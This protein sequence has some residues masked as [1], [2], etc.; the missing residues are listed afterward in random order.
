MSSHN[1]GVTLRHGAGCTDHSAC[2]WHVASRRRSV[3]V[4]PDLGS[5]QIMPNLRCLQ[6]KQSNTMP[7][8]EGTCFVP[9]SEFDRLVRI[10][11]VS[12]SFVASA[13][14][15]ALSICLRPCKHVISPRPVDISSSQASSQR[16]HKQEMALTP[17]V[18]SSTWL[19]RPRSADPYINNW[20]PSAYPPDPRP[21]YGD[22]L[23]E[24]LSGLYQAIEARRLNERMIVDEWIFDCP[25]LNSEYRNSLT[26]EDLAEAFESTIAM[27]RHAQMGQLE[28]GIPHSLQLDFE[29]AM[30]WDQIDQNCRDP[31]IT[32]DTQRLFRA[33]AY[34][35]YCCRS[36][37]LG[38]VLH[39]FFIRH[40]QWIAMHN[41]RRSLWQWC[42]A[43]MESGMTYDMKRDCAS[44]LQILRPDV[45]MLANARGMEGSIRKLPHIIRELEELLFDV[46]VPSTRR[47]RL[48]RHNSGSLVRWPDRTDSSPYLGRVV[49]L[50]DRDKLKNELRFH[51]KEAERNRKKLARMDSDD[52]YRFGDRRP[53]PYGQRRSALKNA[54]NTTNLWAGSDDDD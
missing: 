5:D 19:T 27:A 32:L 34:V 38:R 44:H 30:Q 48:S 26:R 17:Y 11:S 8:D 25:D 52:E 39:D 3:S 28:A 13:L 43:I 45:F 46:S 47:G 20:F 49:E 51:E 21:N 22:F 50:E 29:Q 33:L 40:V 15:F 23:H 24:Y 12:P 2:V 42:V 53:K 37:S 14:L 16:L 41:G 54:W 1:H 35:S 31:R 6:W 10:L 36:I 4:Q 7:V 9:S 18:P